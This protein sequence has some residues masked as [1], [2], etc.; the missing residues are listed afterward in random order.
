MRD[1]E[2]RVQEILGLRSLYQIQKLIQ[3][4]RESGEENPSNKRNHG[5]VRSGYSCTNDLSPVGYIIRQ[6]IQYYT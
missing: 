6:D 5:E 3:R 2:A 1:I 4:E